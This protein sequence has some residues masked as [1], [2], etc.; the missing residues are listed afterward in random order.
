MKKLQVSELASAGLR[1][2]DMILL[3]GE[4]FTARDAAHRRLSELLAAGEPLPFP[5][6]GAVIYYCGPAKAPPGRVIGSCGPT[7]SRRMDCYAPALYALGV[8]A[9]IGKGARGAE[10]ADSCLR[11]GSLY[12]CAVGGAGALAAARVTACRVEAFA[13]LGCEAVLRLTV[14]DFPLITAIDGKG[15]NIFEPHP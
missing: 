15:G 11:G 12:L 10:V 2:G 7:T 9:T 14:K 1:A 6:D 3:S 8:A 13:E 5:L 4:L